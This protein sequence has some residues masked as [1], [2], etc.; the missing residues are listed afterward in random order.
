MLASYHRHCR[1]R[2]HLRGLALGP[3]RKNALVHIPHRK[4]HLRNDTTGLITARIFTNLGWVR[5][6]ELKK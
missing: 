3:P 6:E 4:I 5:P 1:W 2:N